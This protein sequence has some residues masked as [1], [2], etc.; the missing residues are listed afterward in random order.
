MGAWVVSVGAWVGDSVSP[1]SGWVVSGGVGRGMQPESRVRV[2]SRAV[3]DRIFFHGSA[4]FGENVNKGT[5]PKGAAFREIAVFS[6]R[7]G[8]KLD[9]GFLGCYF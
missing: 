5:A 3:R 2:R 6:R 7:V 1:V 9:N 8:K 4:S